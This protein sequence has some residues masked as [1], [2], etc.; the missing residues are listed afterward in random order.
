M[1]KMLAEEIS[2]QLVISK[3]I[4]IDN[5]SYY[6]YGI[7]IVLEN[8][9]TFLSILIVAILTNSLLISIVYII[10]YCPI[11]SYVG[12]YHCKKFYQCYLTSLTLFILLIYFNYN[13]S[14]YKG[15][16]SIILLVISSFTIFIFA[17]INYS[18]K[19][20]DEL[21]TRK[22]KIYSSVLTILAIIGYA[23][24][25]I[26]KFSEIS[27]AISWGVFAVFILMLVSLID[28]LLGEEG[29]YYEK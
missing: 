17:P 28:N 23:L 27:F 24:F 6:T 18:K 22:Y 11:R 7:E 29:N 4:S 14:Y 26:L 8:I 3:I 9:I 1:L 13:F 12:G 19:L 25:A 5:R 10:V 15:L 2:L 20:L 21:A 16:I